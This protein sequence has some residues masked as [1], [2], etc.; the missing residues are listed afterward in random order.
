MELLTTC[1][2]VHYDVVT[3]VLRELPQIHLPED[4][5]EYI[6]SFLTIQRIQPKELSVVKASSDRGDY[7]LSDV[8]KDNSTS[9]WISAEGS[10]PQG[11]GIVYLQFQ[12][13]PDL[14]LRRVSSVSIRIPPLPYGPLSLLEFRIDHSPEKDK[15]IK[16][17]ITMKLKSVSGMQHFE[18][19]PTDTREIR[20][21]CLSNMVSGMRS[22][23]GFPLT[24]S[25]C[26]GLFA[27]SFQ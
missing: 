10:M 6:G 4:T 7:P 25:S 1:D 17:N 12:V 16:G 2:T 3:S 5:V 23:L 13:A 8:L 15:W 20:L 18:L 21:V 22:G 11:R 19:I 9:W 14:Q 27:V 24:Y 26:V